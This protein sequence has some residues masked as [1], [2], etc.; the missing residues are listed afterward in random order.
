MSGEGF[1]ATDGDGE[2]RIDRLVLEIPGF[3]ATQASDLAQ[4]V[5]QR[6]A[7]SGISASRLQLGVTLG[8]VGA[9]TGGLAARIAAALMERLV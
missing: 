7:L 2:V 1:G 9:D 3:D 5:A 6:L 8:P 4:D